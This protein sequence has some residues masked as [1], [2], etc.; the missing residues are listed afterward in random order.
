MH[1]IALVLAIAAV[2]EALIALHLVRQL[3]AERENTRT[4]QARV[5]EL[6]R[7]PP[8]Q[9]A[10]ATLVTVPTQPTASPFTAVKRSAPAQTQSAPAAGNAQDQ[11]Q[12]RQQVNA[13][14]ERQRNLLHDPDYREA[15][16]TQQKMMLAQGNPDVAQELNLTADEVD[17]LFGTLADQTLR[18]MDMP[19]MWEDAPTDPAKVQELQRK[20]L[21]QQNANE[22]ELKSAIGDAKYREWQ[23]YQTT[24]PARFEAIRLRSLLANAGVPLD[25]SLA[26]PLASILKEQHKLEQ[27]R[28][29]QYV[30]TQGSA[31]SAN[32]GFT[33]VLDGQN[34]VQVMTNSVETMTKSLRRQ[35]D[36]LARVLTAEQLK[37][38]E[39][40]HNSQ[41]QM[42]RVQTQLMRAQQEAGTLESGQNITPMINRAEP[43]ALMETVIMRDDVPA[44]PSSD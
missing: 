24:A 36:A 15:M 2:G 1:K 19:S 5:T 13:A 10:A 26:R 16:L 21:E 14:M 43:G 44:P 39:E 33:S 41:L 4:L 38:I 32:V 7:R 35:R 23:E 18:S 17:R 3:H 22:A 25:P 9:T 34:A 11:Q 42:Q 12:L 29:E 28:L 20:M 37:V 8:Q 27:E 31:A 6:E 40:Q 30:A